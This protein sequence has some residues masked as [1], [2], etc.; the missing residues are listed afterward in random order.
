MGTGKMSQLVKCLPYSKEDLSLDF[1]DPGTNLGMV[2]PACDHRVLSPHIKWRTI[3]QESQ[4]GPLAF[5][6]MHYM[7]RQMARARACTHTPWWGW[8]R[9][10]AYGLTDT[11]LWQ[12]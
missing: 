3:E 10:W 9:Q 7:G 12:S 2:G 6:H 4:H 11:Q 8:G 1:Q 5:T